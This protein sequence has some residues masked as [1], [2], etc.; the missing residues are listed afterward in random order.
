MCREQEIIY[1]RIIEKGRPRTYFLALQAIKGASPDAP[2]VYK[3]YDDAFNLVDRKEAVRSLNVKR[4]EIRAS[5]ARAA[6]A[7]GGGGLQAG[8]GAAA[9]AA[10]V[11][12]VAAAGGAPLGGV[13]PHMEEVALEA[14]LGCGLDWKAKVVALGADGA[15]VMQGEE[16]GV[17][18]LLVKD[19]PDAL[20]THCVAHNL[21]LGVAKAADGNSIV[22]AVE[23]LLQECY[24]MYGTSPKKQAE[25]RAVAV[26][27]EDDDIMLKHKTIHG[28]RWLVA[29]G[30][31]VKAC[32]SS[33]HVMVE[34]LSQRV[35]KIGY[36]T[37]D[38][39]KVASRDKAVELLKLLTSYHVAAGL[40]L[41]MD[42]HEVLDVLSLCFQ[43]SDLTVMGVG[44]AVQTAIDDIARL[45]EGMVGS[46]KHLGGFLSEYTP[47]TAGSN[48]G[49]WRGVE[50]HGGEAERVD[51]NEA[52]KAYRV[53]VQAD[54][55][56]RFLTPTSL[57]GRGC[58]VV[59]A[60]GIFDHH[61]WPAVDE[62]GGG[63]F[64][65]ADIEVLVQHWDKRLSDHAKEHAAS[66]FHALRKEVTS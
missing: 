66:Q 4:E 15:K 31:A 21:Q 55:Q 50:I 42:A 8:G 12:A 60:M 40:H 13:P 63:D 16:G 58:N 53:T 10:A 23:A 26:A 6:A 14:A 44:R 51:F 41:L 20:V 61:R 29:M 62:E 34:D 7:T 5:R 45:E 22:V 48:V 35:A 37:R 47:G 57:G 39:K 18:A 9:A 49:N 65:K 52:A 27:M 3:T 17:A 1:V 19:V 2:A 59:A 64:G 25:L 38:V 33:F 30:R 32:M 11:A 28:I 54:L 24:V 56:S 46:K 36:T 43:K